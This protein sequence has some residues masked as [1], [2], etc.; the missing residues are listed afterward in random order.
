MTLGGGAQW[1]SG[2]YATATT[3]TG[4]AARRDQGSP[5]IASL[6][7]SYKFTPQLTAQL[8]INNLFDKTYYDFAGNQI[9]Y[10]TPRNA[11]LTLNYKF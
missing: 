3:S 4:V 6:M 9:F 10:G 8:N 2:S 5:L 1:Q 7:A 11:M